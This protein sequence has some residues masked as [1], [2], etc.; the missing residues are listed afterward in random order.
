MQQVPT[1][2]DLLAIQALPQLTDPLIHHGHFHVALVQE[3]LLLLE[4]GILLLIKLVTN[5]QSRRY[6]LTVALTTTVRCPVGESIS[7]VS[8]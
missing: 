7:V 5:L 1:C 4:L 6:K 3:L 2:L 8:L